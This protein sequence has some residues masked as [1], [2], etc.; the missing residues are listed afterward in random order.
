[1][2]MGSPVIITK[3]P[4]AEKMIQKYNFGIAVNPDNVDEIVEAINFLVDNPDKSKEMG[5]N[6]RRAVL[7]EF[8][9]GI[10]EKK[11]LAL[12]HMLAIN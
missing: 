11:L 12:C 1:M 9:W 3:Y 2:S 4:Y 7:E 6:G 5:E 8:N 10:E